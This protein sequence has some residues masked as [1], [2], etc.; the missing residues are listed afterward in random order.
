MPTISVILPVYNA[1]R[2]LKEAIDSILQQT[3]SDF[4]LLLINDGSTD[5]SEQIIASYTDPRIVYIKNE[6][7]EGLIYS[8]NKAIDL[9][10]GRYIARMD[11]DDVSLPQRF[12]KQLRYLEEHP[13]VGV[14]AATVSFINERGEK[15]GDWP[16]DKNAISARTIRKKMASECCIAHPTVFLTAV[17]LKRYKYNPLQRNIE[18]YDLWLRMLDDNIVIGKVGEDLLFYRIHSSSV[19]QTSWEELIPQRRILACKKQY[20]QDAFKR[21]RFTFFN[22]TILLTMP[23]DF[24]TIVKKAIFKSKSRGQA[25]GN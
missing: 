11:A 16:L 2:F 13:D 17:L 1:E 24:A 14:V 21:S 3:F 18:D 25:S 5:G 7:N 19:T 9:A 12:E 6:K 22:L 10:R 15:I 23:L 8:L 20:L 4:E